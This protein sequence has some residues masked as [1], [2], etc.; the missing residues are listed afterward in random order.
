MGED[1]LSIKQQAGVKNVDVLP[2]FRNYNVQ[3]NLL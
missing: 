1:E 3:Y 2:I